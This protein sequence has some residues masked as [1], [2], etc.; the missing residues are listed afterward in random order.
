M[1]QQGSLALKLFYPLLYDKA[2]CH[3]LLRQ[4]LMLTGKAEREAGYETEG[5]D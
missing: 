1:L 5:G 2:I 4:S 3:E